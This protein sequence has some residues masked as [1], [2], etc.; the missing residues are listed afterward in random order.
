MAERD[1]IFVLSGQ[2]AADTWAG[3]L[4]FSE[5]GF[6]WQRA[7]MPAEPHV[8]RVHTVA[9][10]ST[11]FVALALDFSGEDTLTHALIS[12]D[13]RAW[14]PAG[15]YPGMG[16]NLAEIGGRLLAFGDVDRLSDPWFSE[17][18][19]ATWQKLD[20]DSALAVADG[21]LALHQ[22]EGELWAVRS[23]NPVEDA[24]I[25]T[26]VELWRTRDGLEW[27]LLGE[28]PESVS[29]NRAAIGSGPNGWVITARRTTFRHEPLE[30]NEE[31]FAWHSRDG[32]S[33]EASR[34][35][36][37]YVD[38]ILADD[39]G[40]I[41]IGHDHGACCAIAEQDV[42][43][44]AWASADGSTWRRL[45]KDGW[46]GRE[47]DFITSISDRVTAVGIDWLVNPGRNYEGWGVG[48]EVDRDE[49][50]R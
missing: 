23:D 6:R 2:P 34:N 30:Q 18:A 43:Q 50:L 4:W 37:Q 48:W 22:A 7:T 15:S 45:Q 11:G 42:R 26:P 5:D 20:T 33:W 27:E 3:Q 44:L 25:K 41:A 1:G 29:A 21:L 17:D 36:P 31:W 49:L 32:V 10:T 40:L 14:H 12:A 47:I 13:G 28:L 38:Q 35:V 8:D 16:T 9:A 24:T 46:R 39:Q 19:A